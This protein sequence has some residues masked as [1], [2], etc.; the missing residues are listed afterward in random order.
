MGE[1]ESLGRTPRDQQEGEDLL[2]I[3]REA[4]EREA[5]GLEKPQVICDNR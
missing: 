3:N 2:G 5:C 1:A 4:A